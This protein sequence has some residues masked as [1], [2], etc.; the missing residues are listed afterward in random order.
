M[1]A[2]RACPAASGYLQHARPGHTRREA[3]RPGASHILTH[4]TCQIG[5][6][7]L[8]LVGLGGI[9]GIFYRIRRAAR[10]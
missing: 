1:P 3:G 9:G 4:I 6:K 7:V 2:E 5:R 8:L 10:S